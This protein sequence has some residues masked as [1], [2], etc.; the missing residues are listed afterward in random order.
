M[1]ISELHAHLTTAPKSEIRFTL[2][3]AELVPA[4]A[5]VTE[6]GRVDRV[7]L[8]CGGTL[9]RSS[10]CL[11]QVWV[12]DDVGHRI[13]AQKLGLILE[14]ATPLFSGEDL[15]VEVEYQA[16][17]ISQFFITQVQ[18][19]GGSALL[20]LGIKQTDCLARDIC[21]PAAEAGESGEGNCC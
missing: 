12:A 3:D 17:W 13:L 14:R 2:P 20:R 9:R 1:T 18:H 11:L 10:V 15:E 19:E 6:V 4:H 7:F 21:L 8:D 5:H 16:R